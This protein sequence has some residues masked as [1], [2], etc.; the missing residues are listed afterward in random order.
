[1]CIFA[2]QHRLNVGL[3]ESQEAL[4][5]AAYGLIG[6]RQQFAYALKSILC[7]SEEEGEL[8]D[9]IFAKYWIQGASFVKGK[10]T[11]KGQLPKQYQSP[12]TLVF[13]GMGEQEGKDAEEARNVSG[14]NR[15]ARLRQTDFSRVAAI[16][17]D[18]LEKIALKLWKQMSLRLKKKWKRM[19]NG[20][21]HLRSTIRSNMGNGGQMIYLK[22]RNKKPRKNRLVILLDVSGSMDKYSFYLLRFVWA[23]RS[24]FE[25][26]DAYVFSTALIRITDYL[27]DKELANAL[28]LMSAK[29]H[30]WSS[31]TQ[32]GEC[33][34]HFNDHYAKRALSGRSMTIVLSDG[35]DTGEPQLLAQQLGL[36]KR[37]SK[38]LIWLNP[39][40]GM[41]GYE[42]TARGMK[43]ALPQVDLFK[44]AHNLDSLLE[45]ENFLAH[46]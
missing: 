5:A 12:G 18:Y 44:S 42:P 23:L 9:R 4:L 39:L 32:I 35:L 20:P 21:I 17:Q 37:R 13:M 41:E 26:V 16:D 15:M 36:I 33:L 29:V 46:V 2:R 43:A 28:A 40:K 3:S 45:L 8:F 10:T 24:R 19:P 1:M 31:G 7:C 25:S 11:I 6:E 34:R 27:K 30:H 38:K 22:R 14:A